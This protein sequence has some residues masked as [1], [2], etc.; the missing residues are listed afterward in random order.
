MCTS[1]K[2]LFVNGKFIKDILEVETACYVVIGLRLIS[3]IKSDALDFFVKVR[4]QKFL[5]ENQ[6]APTKGSVK[7]V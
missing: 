5:T 2:V 6:K 1:G 3:K 4:A 7:K